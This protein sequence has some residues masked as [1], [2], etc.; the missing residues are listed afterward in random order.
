MSLKLVL[1]SV[2]IHDDD[3]HDIP[4]LSP[5][6]ESQF[7]GTYLISPSFGCWVHFLCEISYSTLFL[8]WSFVFSSSRCSDFLHCLS[9]PSFV[10]KTANPSFFEPDSLALATLH[11]RHIVRQLHPEAIRDLAIGCPDS[12]S[13]PSL[14]TIGDCSF[15]FDFFGH[16]TSITPGYIY[17]GT[18]FNT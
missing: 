13:F 15:Y 6:F 5:N 14:P 1:S 16:T 18:W 4:V 12:S 3:L 8:I 9:N 11:S 10:P 7:T 2:F 17:V